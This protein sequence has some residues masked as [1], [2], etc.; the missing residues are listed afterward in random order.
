MDDMTPKWAVELMIRFEKL[1]AK[2]TANEERYNSHQD[3]TTR[4]VKDH[5][6][7]LRAIE[8]KLWGVLG[9]AGVVAA[10]ISYLAR[11]F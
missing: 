1:D 11:G 8:K 9:G 4:N 7:R 2:I 5:E 10:I 3:W 6:V